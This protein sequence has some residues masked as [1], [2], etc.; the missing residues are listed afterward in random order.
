M[1]SRE[2]LNRDNERRRI[3]RTIPGSLTAE[4]LRALIDYNP[5]TGEMTWRVSRGNVAA[6][7]PVAVSLSRGYRIMGVDYIKYPAH[8]LAW[9]YVHGEWPNQ[10]L[11][12]INGIRADNRMC[13]LREATGT[14]NNMNSDRRC[15]S[16]NLFR[17]VTFNKQKRRWQAKYSNEHVG[18]FRTP[19]EANIAYLAEVNRQMPSGFELPCHR[20]YNQQYGSE[21]P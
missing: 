4:R 16:S 9:L 13:N 12:H 3:E 21:I 10:H 17:G 14:Q 19:E 15:D 6:G 1:K 20:A 2:E 8:R 18:F 11:D 7:A 5:S